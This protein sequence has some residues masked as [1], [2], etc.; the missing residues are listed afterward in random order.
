MADI[1]KDEQI[2]FHKGSLNTLLAERTELAKMVDI[3][4][5]LIQAH[6]QELYKLGV[7]LTPSSAEKLDDKLKK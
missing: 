7:K 6:A 1:S 3:V 4:D 5:S 2:G